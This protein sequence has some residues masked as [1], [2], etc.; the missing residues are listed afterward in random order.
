MVL[1]VLMCKCAREADINLQGNMHSRVFDL[2]D[3]IP[4]K[5]GRST[6][7]SS[8]ESFGQ[9]KIGCWNQ[10]PMSLLVHIQQVNLS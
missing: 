5:F 1:N 3:F 9:K 2:S 8:V 6:Q 4:N 10:E 7:H